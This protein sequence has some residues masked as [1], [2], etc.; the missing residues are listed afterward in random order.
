MIIR[1]GQLGDV[2]SDAMYD[3]H[4]NV[5]SVTRFHLNAALSHVL[6]KQFL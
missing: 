5:L 4:I 3:T 6:R 2:P 1:L